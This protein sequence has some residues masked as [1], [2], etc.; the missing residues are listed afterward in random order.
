LRKKKGRLKPAITS[1]EPVDGP[2]AFCIERDT[3]GACEL[4]QHHQRRERDATV[5]EREAISRF[6]AR[7]DAALI[8]CSMPS[9]AGSMPHSKS[10]RRPA[11]NAGNGYGES[12]PLA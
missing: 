11:C 7:Q 2:I 12:R 9:L 4:R 10:S 3:M 8:N 1:D 6:L 5:V